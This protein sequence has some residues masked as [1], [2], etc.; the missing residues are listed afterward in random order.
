MP[1]KVKIAK[2]EIVETA[3]ELVRKNGIGAINARAVAAALNCSTQ[4]VFS[5]FATMEQLQAAVIMSA[6]ERYLNFLKKEVESKSYPPYKSYGMGYIR[7]AREEKELFKLLFMCDR[8]GAEISPTLDFEESVQMIKR[9]NGVS[10]ETAT[11]M[12]LEVWTCVHGI[13]V[14]L[15]TSFL[16]LEWELISD[17]LSDVYLGI[18][19]RHLSKEN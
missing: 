12:H 14:M 19:A 17:M 1:P 9:D 3:L 4:P 13:G 15:A 2:E 10:E 11:R 6:Y 18:R 8:K 16:S 5:N 7:F